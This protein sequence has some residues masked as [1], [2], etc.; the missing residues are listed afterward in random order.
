MEVRVSVQRFA[1]RMEQKLRQND[2]KKGGWLDEDPFWLLGR[3]L[4][5]LEELR[6][7]LVAGKG[8][9]AEAADVAN[10]V[11]MASEAKTAQCG[12]WFYPEYRGQEATV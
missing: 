2:Q 5:E 6:A 3:A 8:Y 9:D 4:E 10:L 1:N 11:M 12:P 7:A